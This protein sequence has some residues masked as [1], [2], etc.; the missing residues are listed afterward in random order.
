MRCDCGSLKGCGGKLCAS[1]VRSLKRMP[2][3]RY[4]VSAGEVNTQAQPMIGWV[5]GIISGEK[6]SAGGSGLHIEGR[7]G[8]S[9]GRR[10]TVAAC[11]FDGIKAGDRLAFGR[12]IYRVVAV[13]K[14]EYE[15]ARLLPDGEEKPV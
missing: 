1:A 5:C 9:V 7:T 12:M 4:P 11:S 3:C 8:G 14:G 10:L 13:E 15:V 6:R 2:L